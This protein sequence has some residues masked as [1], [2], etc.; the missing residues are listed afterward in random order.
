MLFTSLHGK[1]IL[2]ATSRDVNNCKHS[3]RVIEYHSKVPGA[4]QFLGN[5]PVGYDLTPA[6]NGAFNFTKSLR[7]AVLH[8]KYYK[9]EH[10]APEALK[11][12]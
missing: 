9:Q 2:N 11:L 1:Y 6:A 10:A 8:F 4:I 3:R 7:A 5:I 12:L